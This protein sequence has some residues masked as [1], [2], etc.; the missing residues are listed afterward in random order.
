M[1]ET[2][3]IEISSANYAKS[4]AMIVVNL[5]LLDNVS[6]LYLVG[7]VIQKRYIYMWVYEQKKNLQANISG[8]VGGE[9][10]IVVV[11]SIENFW[12]D[13]FNKMFFVLLFWIK[14]SCLI[15]NNII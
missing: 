7:R 4:V 3:C 8:V 12:G 10:Y 9:Q 1:R 6:N 13:I 5:P 11:V 14:F 15:Y 2:H